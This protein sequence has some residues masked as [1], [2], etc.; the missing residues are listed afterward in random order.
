MKFV[1]QILLI[2]A[3]AF[4]LSIGGC[5][6]NTASTSQPETKATQN[7]VKD[8]ANNSNGMAGPVVGSQFSNL[9]FN[10]PNIVA[11]DSNT[12]FYAPLVY[13]GT[14]QNS[15]SISYQS[16]YL[17]AICKDFLLDNGTRT[18]KVITG[19]LDSS[20]ALTWFSTEYLHAQ[21]SNEVDMVQASKSNYDDI[22]MDTTPHMVFPYPIKKGATWSWQTS[23]GGKATATILG[24]YKITKPS[25]WPNCL[26]VQR[27]VTYQDPS[28]NQIITDFYVPGVGLVKEDLTF[29]AHTASQSLTT[30]SFDLFH[31]DKP[32]NPISFIGMP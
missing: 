3:L 15:F 26:T 2:L 10:D 23:D 18:I 8:Q 6:A 14:V 22:Y 17:G 29:F 31:S 28:K 27:T 9:E 32:V 4:A 21:S 25:V 11:L 12:S 24:G 13:L 1:K 5:G 20:G 7:I 16:D 19:T 30:S